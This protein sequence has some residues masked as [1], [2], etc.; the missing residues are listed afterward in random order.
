MVEKFGLA[1]LTGFYFPVLEGR[2]FKLDSHCR[3]PHQSSKKPLATLLGFHGWRENTEKSFS[4]RRFCGGSGAVFFLPSFHEPSSSME[5]PLM[6]MCHLHFPIT[7]PCSHVMSSL[8]VVHKEE[9]LQCWTTFSTH[10]S[11]LQL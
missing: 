2:P 6:S 1:H 11:F 5:P 10:A 9:S 7:S 8:L 4:A 3:T